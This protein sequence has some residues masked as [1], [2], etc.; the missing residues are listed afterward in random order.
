VKPLKFTI[1]QVKT[2]SACFKITPPGGAVKRKKIIKEQ[3]KMIFS[4]F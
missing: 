3:A 4:M 1:E 2:N